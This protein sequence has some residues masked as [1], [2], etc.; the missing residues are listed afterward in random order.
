[1]EQDEIG[2]SKIKDGR[3]LEKRDFATG[4]AG[5][6]GKWEGEAAGQCAMGNNRDK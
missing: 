2:E 5:K 3:D 1:M 6:M 4:I